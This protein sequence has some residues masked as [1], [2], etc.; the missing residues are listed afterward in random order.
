MVN[1]PF[2]VCFLETDKQHVVYVSRA[3]LLSFG[4]SHTYQSR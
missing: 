3:T 2:S 4:G 1:A